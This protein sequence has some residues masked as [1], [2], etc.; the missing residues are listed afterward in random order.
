[1]QVLW[2]EEKHGENLMQGFSENYVWFEA[3]YDSSKV[4]TIQSQHFAAIAVS[5]RALSKSKIDFY[6]IAE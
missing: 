1:M 6:N 2:E 4:I 5:G 3:P